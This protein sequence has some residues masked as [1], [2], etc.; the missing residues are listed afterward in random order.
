MFQLSG[1]ITIAAVGKLRRSHWQ[2]AQDDYLQR[3]QRYTTADLVEVKDVTGRSIPDAVAMQREGEQLLKAAE[4]AS[5]KIALTPGG[6]LMSS[7]K[8][9]TYLR[10]QV[11]V[12]GRIAFLI[13]GPVGFADEVVARCD[14][15]L[16]LSPLTFPHELARIILLEQLY[17]ACTILSGEPYHK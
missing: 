17:R 7:P 15:Q 1:H 13:G 16:S 3:L 5:L 8:L 11:E 6:K 4:N 10:K 9:A 2:A 14:E 12:Y